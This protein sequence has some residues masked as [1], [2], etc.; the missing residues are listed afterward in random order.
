ME[1]YGKELR[2][3]INGRISGASQ[4]HIKKRIK[5]NW[6]GDWIGKTRTASQSGRL[7]NPDRVELN[8]Q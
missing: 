8:F 4:T 7:N 6:D 3:I 1:K 2:L 5:M